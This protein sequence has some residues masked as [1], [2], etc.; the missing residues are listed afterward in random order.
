MKLAGESDMNDEFYTMFMA[1][2]G[3]I[4]DSFEVQPLCIDV[5]RMPCIC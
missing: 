1:A 4:V 5:A 2:S 3:C